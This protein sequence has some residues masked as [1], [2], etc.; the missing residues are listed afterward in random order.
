VSE[1]EQADTIVI[2]APM[3]NL[4]IPS[5]LKAWLDQVIVIGRTAGEQPSAAGTPVVVV[6]S[7]GGS[8]APGTPREGFDFVETYLQKVLG[9]MLGLSVEFIVPELTMARVN[10]AMAAL[11]D[12]ADA[13][14]ARA[15][16]DAAAR[17]KGL[18][19]QLAA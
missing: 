12:R 8:Y 6:A 13:S 5:T 9:G 19:A 17:G 14:R 15:H 1:L 10:P 18:A 7:R 3:Y 11:A 4:T 16:E 2:G